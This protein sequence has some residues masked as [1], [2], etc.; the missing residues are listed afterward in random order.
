MVFIDLTAYRC[1]VPLVKTKLAIKP[2][3][4]GEQIHLVLSDHG[5]RSDV[6]QFLK[7]QGHELIELHNEPASLALLV[8]I[9]RR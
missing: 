4:H 1:P 8:T 2:M 9:V 5:S 7:N 3:G 6:P